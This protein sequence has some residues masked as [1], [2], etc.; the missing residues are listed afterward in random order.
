[1]KRAWAVLVALCFLFAPFRAFAASDPAEFSPAITDAI[2]AAAQRV[3]NAQTFPSAD[4]AIVRDGRIVYS[5][6]FGNG[7]DGSYVIGSVTKVFTATAVMQLVA[8]GKIG[9]DDPIARWFP[10]FPNAK[11]ITVRELLGHR[12]GIPD[13]L[14]RAF[15]TGRE[16][17][18][19]TPQ[20]IIDEA[21][22]WTPDF[23]PGTDWNYSNTGYALLARIVEIVS[24]LPIA[25]YERE[26]IYAVAGM[27]HTANGVAPTGGVLLPGA[28]VAQAMYGPQE[29]ANDLSWYYGCG[30]IVSTAGDIAKFDIAL[31]NST[32]LPKRWFDEMRKTQTADTLAPGYGDGLGLFTH[33]FGDR[34]IV[35]HHGG[36]PGYSA[37]NRMIP[38]DRFAIIVLDNSDTNADTLL[39]PV[40]AALYPDATAYAKAHPP[41]ATDP[42]PAFAARILAVTQ[43]FLTGSTDLDLFSP[44][45]RNALTPPVL[46]QVKTAHANL[47]SVTS[48]QFINKIYNSG[49][50]VYTYVAICTNGRV[51]ITLS[52]DPAGKIGGFRFLQ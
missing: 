44:Q 33:R 45:M 9:L 34:T 7:A 43:G 16:Y 28:Y 32:L 31:M 41:I 17:S 12:S 23:A 29:H 19:V 5:K 10:A 22:T 20:Q 21:A 25:Q 52:I 49:Y 15:A 51:P 2:G 4:I 38:E 27:T 24:G 26:H 30:D 46:D 48:L 14:P 37:D 50:R 35:D 8:A 1:M 42:D 18:P 11:A 39:G 40:E 13:Y 47:G 6:S 36:E 3:V